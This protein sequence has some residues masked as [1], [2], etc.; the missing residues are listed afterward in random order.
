M[1]NK[2]R[3]SLKLTNISGIKN[4]YVHMLM[5]I[6]FF[7]GSRVKHKDGNWKNNSLANLETIE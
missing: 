2:K 1:D 4:F 7:N 6:V 5:S 3:A